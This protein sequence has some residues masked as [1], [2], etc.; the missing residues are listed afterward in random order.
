MERVSRWW[1]CS[2]KI[3]LFFCF[4]HSSSA[5]LHFISMFYFFLPNK[6]ETLILGGWERKAMILGFRTDLSNTCLPVQIYERVLRCAW[7]QLWG[8]WF[9]FFCFSRNPDRNVHVFTSLA[10][11]WEDQR[12]HTSAL[13]LMRES[14]RE[15]NLTATLKDNRLWQGLAN[16]GQ[17]LL[18]SVLERNIMKRSVCLEPIWELR[19]KVR[20]LST[21]KNMWSFSGEFEDKLL[22]KCV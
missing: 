17:T 7:W 16:N 10:L 6:K 8:V 12:D 4:P 3:T 5:M 13:W 18:S 9:S 21:V 20:I 2:R 14:S 11:I 19:W 15:Q 1:Q 22:E